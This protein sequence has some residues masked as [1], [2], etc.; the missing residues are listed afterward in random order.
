MKTETNETLT[1]ALAA[2]QATLQAIGELHDT[3]LQQNTNV[4]INMVAVEAESGYAYNWRL[5]LL[6]RKQCADELDALLNRRNGDV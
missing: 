2:A 4:E 5:Q 6:P 1:R 3:W